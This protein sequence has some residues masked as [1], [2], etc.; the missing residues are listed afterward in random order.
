MISQLRITLTQKLVRNKLVV[1]IIFHY[2]KNVESV[3]LESQRFFS[4]FVALFIMTSIKMQQTLNKHKKK[5]IEK[6]NTLLQLIAHLKCMKSRC[7]NHESDQCYIVTFKHYEIDSKHLKMWHELL[8][9]DR[10]NINVC[11]VNIKKKLSTTTFKS[12]KSFDDVVAKIAKSFT[13]FTIID[14]SDIN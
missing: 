12:K 5:K 1:Y 11:F 10:H 9:I 3:I 7:L 13:S 14:K 6:K 4:S 2:R 8:I